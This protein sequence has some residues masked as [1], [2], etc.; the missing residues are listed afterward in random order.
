MGLA[1][2]RRAHP[3]SAHPLPRPDARRRTMRGTS[4]STPSASG[5]RG[6]VV[7]EGPASGAARHHRHSGSADDLTSAN[8]VRP[9]VDALPVLATLGSSEVEVTG[10]DVGVELRRAD[11][12]VIAVE[13]VG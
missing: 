9:R 8:G 5:E 1:C 2:P 10:D 7:N 6:Q 13:V 12:G 3:Y 11:G 4:Y